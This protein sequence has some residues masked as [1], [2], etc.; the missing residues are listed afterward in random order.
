MLSINKQFLCE[1]LIVK[2]AIKMHLSRI[3][4]RTIN[5]KNSLTKLH[6][7]FEEKLEDTS[8]KSLIFF[9]NI[10]IKKRIPKTYY[11][12]IYGVRNSK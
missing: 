6:F 7:Y 2:N 5:F 1:Y 3:D 4:L 12:K 11:G 10:H 8:N 9:Y